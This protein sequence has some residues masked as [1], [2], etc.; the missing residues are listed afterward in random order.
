MVL[1]DTLKWAEGAI[2]G[3]RQQG[4]LPEDCVSAI[5]RG[6]AFDSLGETGLGM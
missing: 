3:A 6:S 2:D 4:Y 5:I 1:S